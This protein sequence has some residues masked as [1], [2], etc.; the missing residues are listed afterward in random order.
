MIIDG[1]SLDHD[2]NVRTQVCVIGSGAGGAVVAK[3][4]AETGV[5]VCLLE[6]GA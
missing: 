3:E 5:E 4:I 6:E 2:C 1:S